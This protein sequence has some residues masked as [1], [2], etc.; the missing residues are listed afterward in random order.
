LRNYYF[1]GTIAT[2]QPTVQILTLRRTTKYNCRLTVPST[3]VHAHGL[4]DGD[5]VLWFPQA[6]GVLLKFNPAMVGERSEEAA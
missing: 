2:M 1:G 3:Y 4:R 5:R 6:D